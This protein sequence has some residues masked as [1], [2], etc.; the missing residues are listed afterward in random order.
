MKDPHDIIIRPHISEKAVALSYGDRL[1]KNEAD[2]KRQYTFIVADSSNKIEIKQALEAIYN[3]GKRDKD[4]RIVVDKVRTI[5]VRGKTRRVGF[6]SKG[7]K[8]DFKKAIV[9]L[10]KGQRLEDYGV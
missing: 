8:P 7:K 5:K 9:T 3:A 4:E 1:A 2:V 6:K 10:A